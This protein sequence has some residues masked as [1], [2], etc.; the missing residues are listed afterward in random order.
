MT[1]THTEGSVIDRLRSVQQSGKSVG[2]MNSSGGLSVAASNPDIFV[3]LAVGGDSFDDQALMDDQDDQDYRALADTSNMAP[4]FPSLDQHELTFNCMTLRNRITLAVPSRFRSSTSF[5]KVERR[6][7][8]SGSLDIAKILL[9]KDIGVHNR[10]GVIGTSCSHACVDAI[11]LGEKYCTIKLHN[12]K[13]KG[14]LE[15]HV[16]IRLP[17][18]KGKNTVYLTPCLSITTLASE[19]FALLLAIERTVEV[20]SSFLPRLPSFSPSEA[21]ELVASVDMAVKGKFNFQTPSKKQRANVQIRNLDEILPLL[22][23]SVN[24]LNTAI[25]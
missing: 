15:H 24:A 22:Y 1:A 16:F 23:S 25:E 19:M 2:L 14:L 7:K 17:S 12:V 9:V 4:N 20:W 6:V 18:V 11:I 21:V 13:A 5:L 3:S 10:G 8:I